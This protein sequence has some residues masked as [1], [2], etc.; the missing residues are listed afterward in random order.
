MLA[1][2]PKFP[3]HPNQVYLSVPQ[4]STSGSCNCCGNFAH[5]VGLRVHLHSHLLRQLEWLQI[6]FMIQQSVGRYAMLLFNWGIFLWEQ[7]AFLIQSFLSDQE[8][9]EQSVA[10]IAL[11]KVSPSQ[12]ESGEVAVEGLPLP[13]KK[14]AVCE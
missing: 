2:T 7:I 3:F 8:Q 14:T 1:R 6:Q 4:G 11:L 5:A 10:F 13:V 12:V 9:S